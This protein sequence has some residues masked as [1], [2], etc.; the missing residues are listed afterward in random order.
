M[1][2]IQHRPAN[3]AAVRRARARA[4]TDRAL[5][6]PDEVVES[7]AEGLLLLDPTG[8]VVQ[9]N[10]VAARLLGESHPDDLLGHFTGGT[11]STDP[12]PPAGAWVL[13]LIRVTS[14]PL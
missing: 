10:T 1:T 5:A 8:H 13:A 11:W 6:M 3:P 12:D 9:A 7:L 2:S 14:P 4:R